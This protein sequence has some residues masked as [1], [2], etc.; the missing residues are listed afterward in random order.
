MTETSKQC[1]LLDNSPARGKS[2]AARGE[3]SVNNLSV[4]AR[5]ELKPNNSFATRPSPLEMVSATKNLP[6]DPFKQLSTMLKQ[7]MTEQ[8]THTTLVI[9]LRRQVRAGLWIG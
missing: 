7:G 4:S 1:R 8:K 2:L 3:C 6:M 5:F 9:A